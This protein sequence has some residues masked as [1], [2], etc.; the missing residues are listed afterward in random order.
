MSTA[1]VRID[2]EVLTRTPARGQRCRRGSRR[3]DEGLVVAALESLVFLHQA[4]VAAMGAKEDVAWETPESLE[5]V[6]IVIGDVRIGLVVHELVAGI[7]VWAADDDHVEGA[8][9][10]SLVQGPVVVPRVWPAVRCAVRVVR[11]RETVS[12]S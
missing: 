3:I 4:E 12:P 7:H 10:F 1:L 5:F 11:P 8:A 9:V 2:G 6:A